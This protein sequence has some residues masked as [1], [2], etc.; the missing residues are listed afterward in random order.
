MAEMSMPV[1]EPFWEAIEL[2]LWRGNGI[3][4]AVTVSTA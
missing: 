4:M 3:V 2:A 1:I